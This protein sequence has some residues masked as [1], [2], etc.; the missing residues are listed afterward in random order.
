MTTYTVIDVQQVAGGANT[1]IQTPAFAVNPAAGDLIVV[2]A[3]SWKAGGT[4]HTIPTDTAGNLY[5]QIGATLRQGGD[6]DVSL[7]ARV[8]AVG[9]SAF[10][11]TSATGGS[12]W[13]AVIA[14]CVR[15]STPIAYNGDVASQVSVSDVANND[16]VTSPAPPAADA[17][18]F[19]V[20]TRPGFDNC[21]VEGAGWNTTGVNGFTAGLKTAAKYGLQ[22]A[23]VS[24]YS[25]YRVGAAAVMGEWTDSNSSGGVRAVIVG[26]FGPAAAPSPVPAALFF[27]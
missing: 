11:V 7:W 23:N 18:F 25:E 20:A 8:N 24:A 6:A 5:A 15:P 3:A 26:S 12:A 14:W 13:R 2:A 9:G 1:S 17:I 21:L 16:P 19:C 22:S 27:V 10:R 4:T